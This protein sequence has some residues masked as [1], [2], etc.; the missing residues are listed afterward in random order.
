[1]G[2][3]TLAKRAFFFTSLSPS[4]YTDIMARPPLFYL[5]CLFCSKKAVVRT[6]DPFFHQVLPNVRAYNMCRLWRK[7]HE[8][9]P[10]SV[11]EEWR[12]YKLPAKSRLPTIAAAL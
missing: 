7:V 4:P 1:M 3:S 8:A 10:V 12:R 11:I 5:P 2:E 9:A 6:A